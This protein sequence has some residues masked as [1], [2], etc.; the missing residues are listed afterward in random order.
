MY[1]ISLVRLIVIPVVTMLVL[2]LFPFSDPDICMAIF[3]AAAAPVGSNV[4]VYAR[5]CDGDYRYA[6]GAVCVSTIFAILTM[7]LLALL[8]GLF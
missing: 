1:A 4:A 5:R 2:K 6:S 3:I 8:Y 7:P